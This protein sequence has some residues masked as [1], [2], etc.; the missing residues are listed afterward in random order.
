MKMTIVLV[1]KI[2]HTRTT[3]VCEAYENKCD[4]DYHN[5]KVF[6][7]VLGDIAYYGVDVLLVGVDF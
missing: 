1:L 7:R 5:N 2:P 3:S 4:Y 6:A